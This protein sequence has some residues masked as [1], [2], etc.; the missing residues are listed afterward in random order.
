[1]LFFRLSIRHLHSLRPYQRDCVDVCLHKFLQQGV[2]KQIVSLP[3]GSGKTVVLSALLKALPSP[4]KQAIKS[5]VL[6]H[7]EELIA[8]AYKQIKLQCRDQVVVIDQA[9]MHADVAQADIIVA[10]VQTLTRKGSKRVAK[11]RPEDFKCII[12]DEAHHAAASTYRQVLDHFQARE[13]TSPIF[14]WG[15]SATVQR[16]DALGLGSIFDEITYRLE[17]LDLIQQGWL[18]D[19]QVTSIK[20]G[21]DLSR[22]GNDRAG[23]DFE[24]N[25]LSLT[26]N[27]PERNRLVV[28]HWMMERNQ[29]PL[30]S[31]LV[32]AANV[33]HVMDLQKTFEAHGIHALAVTSHSKVKERRSH[34][35]LFRHRQVPVMIN[36]GIFT[37]GTDVHI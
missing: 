25:Q 29:R 15:C 24:L 12:I 1:M 27:T 8:Q 3:V 34:L 26:I 2:R 7:R 9:Q 31:T 11:Y 28:E 6:A 18:C 22:V 21:V 30:H 35:E 32:F 14:V 16:H 23:G 37:E 10:S 17:T 19:A 13:P 33:Q 36:C 20:T 4:N 5:L